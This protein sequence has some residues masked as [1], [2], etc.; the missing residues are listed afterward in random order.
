[1]KQKVEELEQEFHDVSKLIR[2][3][4]DRFDKEKVEDF[5]DSVQQFLHSMIDHQKQVRKIQIEIRYKRF[6]LLPCG[7]VILNEQKDWKMMMKKNKLSF[8][9]T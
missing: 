1:M 8:N 3:E 6:R 9:K 2:N 4:L 7:K 5:R